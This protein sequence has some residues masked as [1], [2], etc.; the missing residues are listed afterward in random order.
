MKTLLQYIEKNWGNPQYCTSCKSNISLSICGAC[1]EH[2]YCGKECQTKHWK[3]GHQYECI[4]GRTKRTGEEEEEEEKEDDNPRMQKKSFISE[5]QDE[6]QE[7]S[8]NDLS[9][10]IWQKISFFLSGDD[11]KNLSMVDKI[12]QQRIR[13]QFFKR[14]R[15]I[16][17]SD[18]FE[19][20]RFLEIVK[21]IEAVT[22][23]SQRDLDRLIELGAPLKD[24]KL[25]ETFEELIV[26][27]QGLTH[28]TMGNWFN[29]FITLPHSL[30]H[31]TMGRGFTQPITLPESL[32]NF[33]MGSY[34]NQ[35]IIL[36]QSLLHF[37]M[38]LFFTQPIV[39]PQSLRHF[40]MGNNFNLPITLPQGLTHFT[41][42]FSFN[43]PITLPQGLTHLTLGG[44]FSQP[45]TLPQG[46]VYLS[47]SIFYP[48]WE[49]IRPNVPN[50]EVYD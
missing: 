33:T 50:I 6:R 3:L 45:I 47:Y 16:I 44:Y 40:I 1:F 12:I 18:M 23:S 37:T 7:I 10:D 46:L 49:E 26:L 41:M 5:E 13:Q 8:L 30:T 32:T 31:F 25:Y 27:P 14:F 28:F 15:W 20:P 36:P 24:V 11:L 34:F 2:V 19:N 48:Y 35:P 4:S 17:T 29:Q 38:G 43:R 9:R 22:I 39:L 42:G 21:D